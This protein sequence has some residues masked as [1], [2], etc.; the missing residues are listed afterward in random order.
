MAATIAILSVGRGV[1]L[2]GGVDGD[3]DTLGDGV[4]DEVGDAVVGWVVGST[5]P[6]HATP[7]SVKAD[8]TGLL[9]DHDPLKPN[10]TVAFV[11]TAPF[12][13]AFAAVTEV[14]DAVTFAFQAWVTCWPGT[15][16][17]PSVQPLTASPRFVTLTFAVKPPGH[18]A[19]TAY[20]TRQPAA[21]SALTATAIP[22]A[23]SAVTVPATSATFDR[24]LRMPCT[25][26]KSSSS[27]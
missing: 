26:I 5:P 11:A 1:E 16:A 23:S 3:T 4:G 6:V 15:N 12:Q 22:P 25:I 19:P 8:G 2:V 10:D 24:V 14:P 27:S 20:V 17:Q 7:F 18:C 13:L 9:P 21:A